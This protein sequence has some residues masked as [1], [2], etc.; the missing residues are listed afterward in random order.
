MRPK[1]RNASEIAARQHGCITTAQLI[2]QHF[3]RPAIKRLGAKGLL[4]KEFRGVW[5]F[6]HAAPSIEA[7]YMA[8]VLACG[9]GAAL[10][11][12][13]AAFHRGLIRRPPSLPEV[14]CPRDKDIPGILS[15]QRQVP[16]RT[17]RGIPTTSV[18]QTIR[19]LAA[20]LPLDDLAKLCHS[21]EIKFGVKRVPFK[22]IKGAAKL[23]AI[24]D[25]DHALLLGEMEREFKRLLEAHGLPL[26]SFNRKR[27][28][29]YIDAR[30]ADPPTTIELQSFKHHSSRAAWEAD[31]ERQRAARRRG[32][33][34]R[35][36]T[37]R[38]VVEEPRELLAELALLLGIPAK[39]Q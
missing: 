23:R 10:S 31:F 9:P 27:G 28:A 17:W 34:F 19:D 11:G 38:D 13:A 18:E 35:A 15:R 37:W 1:L 30:Y 26:P 21:A 7:H 3:S 24:Y 16:S 12:L 29:H 22:G 39:L 33:E 5:R 2:E 20:I 14:S 25:G 4:H 6:G 36:Y 32:D 8:A